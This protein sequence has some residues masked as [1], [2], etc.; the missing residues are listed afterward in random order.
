MI[1]VTID[2]SVGI[3]AVGGNFMTLNDPVKGVLDEPLYPL[4][5]PV[6]PDLIENVA[7]GAFSYFV[8]RGRLTE[9]DQI[10][11]GTLAVDLRNHDTMYQFDRAGIDPGRR[12]RVALD[13]VTIIDGTVEDWNYDYDPSGMSTASF[14]AVD[15]LGT[16]ARKDFDEWTALASQTAG[17]RISSAL[18]RSEVAYPAG[19]RSIEPGTT[20][21]QGD[22]VT[23]G[24][25]VLNYLQLVARS[26]LGRLFAARDGELTF[27]D[28]RTFV[29]EVSAEFGNDGIPFSGIGP[30][31]GAETLYTRVSVDREGGIA[32]TVS[33]ADA[34]ARYGVRTL[35][36]SGLL[37]DTDADAFSLAAT[38][39]SLYK[40]PAVRLQTLSVKLHGLT[41]D[42]RL[43]VLSLDIGDAVTVTWTPAT[44][45]LLTDA[46]GVPLTD[47][48]G[49]ALTTVPGTPIT[50]TLFVEGIALSGSASGEHVC[51][52]SLSPTQLLPQPF[53]LNDATFG[54]LDTGRLDY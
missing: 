34:V 10:D 36:L 40:S 6:G 32:Q 14:V 54:V 27:L 9:L 26:E 19:S 13:G 51:D 31:Y 17:Q 29:Y 45:S 12:V 15:A 48:Y 38:L 21:L 28:R 5:D 46:N 11:A 52:L 41:A 30:V 3:G 1:D 47:Q 33:D 44:V 25:N 4:F 39:L 43:I 37:M 24:S 18:D 20:Q 42:Q 53:I 16:L 35:S 2:L 8:R 23:H 22:L 50:Q 7:V 49:Q